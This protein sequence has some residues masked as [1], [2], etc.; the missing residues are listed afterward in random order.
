MGL[1]LMRRVGRIGGSSKGS[2][3]SKR[4]KR[5]HCDSDSDTSDDS[6]TTNDSETTDD[7]DSSDDS[8]AD[9][10]HI[11]KK[12]CERN[13]EQLVP[14]VSVNQ[15]IVN[16][17]LPPIVS[18][19]VQKPIIKVNR[20][21]TSVGTEIPQTWGDLFTLT[22]RF[23]HTFTYSIGNN[24]KG[25]FEIITDTPELNAFL[26]YTSKTEKKSDFDGNGTATIFSPTLVENN[27]KKH[28]LD[29]VMPY[30]CSTSSFS[31]SNFVLN[32]SNKSSF[33]ILIPLN[34]VEHNYCSK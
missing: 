31:D 22:K 20:N 30:A 19:N 6:D 2:R 9:L 16:K 7:S 32:N 4:S 21:V 17:K 10:Q 23:G 26:S 8:E 3:G 15:S 33:N 27:G 13:N 5:K 29:I 25:S 18:V 1:G 12:R 11:V 28:I 14:N 24:K 34:F